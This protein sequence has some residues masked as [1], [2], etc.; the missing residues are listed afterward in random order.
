[1]LLTNMEE[2]VLQLRGLL[3]KYTDTLDDVEILDFPLFVDKWGVGVAYE[4][5][6]RV[7][8]GDIMYKCINAHTSTNEWT[9]DTAH[10]LWG[11][12]LAGDD[13]IIEWTQPQQADEAYKKGDKVI[14]NG[15]VYQSTIDNNVW[16][17]TAYPSGWTKIE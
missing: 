6:K 14:F 1:M 11:R 12:V 5:G 17:P 4:V 15:E 2:A 13:F 9:P 3:T 7:M 10:S 8:Y 16:S